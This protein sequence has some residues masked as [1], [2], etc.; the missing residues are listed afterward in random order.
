MHGEA[1]ILFA[2]RPSCA[3]WKLVAVKYLQWHDRHKQVLNI[4]VNEEHKEVLVI[5]R[6]T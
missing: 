5:K 3:V 6:T 4:L 1:V 2:D